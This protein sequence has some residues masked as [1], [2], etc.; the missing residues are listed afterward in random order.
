MPLE[1]EPIYR[2]VID[3]VRF[4]KELHAV[5][6]D[7]RRADEFVDNAKRLLARNPYAGYQSIPSHV[8][9]LPIAERLGRAALYYRFDGEVVELLSIRPFR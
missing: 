5:S 9:F 6:S 4:R 8:W 3:S 1:P 2:T 7:S